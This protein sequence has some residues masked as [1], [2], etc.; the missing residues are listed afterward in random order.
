MSA[1]RAQEDGEGPTYYA[2]CVRGL[3]SDHDAVIFQ[4]AVLTP[5]PWVITSE[6]EGLGALR[7]LIIDEEKAESV[8]AFTGE[9]FNGGLGAPGRHLSGG[10]E[11]LWGR[12][13]GPRHNS[14]EATRK[15]PS[16]RG[17][18]RRCGL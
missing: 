5:L 17:G 14:R 3:H 18:L 1:T 8:V 7:V 13:G 12:T 11:R 6:F 4:A 10:G 15:L 2:V 16:R 9:R